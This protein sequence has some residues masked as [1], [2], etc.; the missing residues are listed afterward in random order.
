MK[1]LKFVNE[2]LSPSRKTKAWDIMNLRGDILGQVAFNSHWRNYVAVLR[3][4][5]FDVNCLGEVMEFIRMQNE[6]RKKE[7]EQNKKDWKHGVMK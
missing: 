4:A 5:I 2:T 3:E 6:L 1:Y 7:L